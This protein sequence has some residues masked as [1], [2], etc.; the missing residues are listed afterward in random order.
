MSGRDSQEGG[1]IDIYRER[2]GERERVIVMT[3]LCC[4]AETTQHCKAIILQ[5]KI[6]K[7]I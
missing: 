1:E 3:D 4:M 7:L 5:L 2:E 6:N